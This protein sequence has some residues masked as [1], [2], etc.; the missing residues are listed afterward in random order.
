MCLALSVSEAWAA[1][2]AGKSSARSRDPARSVPPGVKRLWSEYPVNQR[3]SGSRASAGPQSAQGAQPSG[4]NESAAKRVIIPIALTLT[5]FLVVILFGVVLR[6]RPAKVGAAAA[7]S[8][9]RK[10]GSRVEQSERNPALTPLE[11][12]LGAV[13]DPAPPQERSTALNQPNQP[14]PEPAEIEL[15]GEGYAEIGER[16]GALLTSA[17]QTAEQ[18]R[19]AARQEAEQIRSEAADRAAATIA[20]ASRDAERARREADD[21]RAETDR[22]SKE[23][24]EAADRYGTEARR[25]LDEERAQRHAD[26]EREARQI[27]QDAVLRANNLVAQATRRQEALIEAAS[28]SEARLEQ[29][30]GVFRGMTSQLE[31]LVQHKSEEATETKAAGDTG[32]APEE[33]LAEA[34]SPQRSGARKA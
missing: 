25:K 30:V 5:G 13:R 1:D 34:L 32:D 20:E 14:L 12:Y 11:N 21:L 8:P 24:R 18:I 2:A 17:H 28:R 29:L 16:V 4:E 22:Y 31:E 10:R 3:P 26:V 33:G 15:T 19:D 6:F 9:A 7:V 23:Q 27:R